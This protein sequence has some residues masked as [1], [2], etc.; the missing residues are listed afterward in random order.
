MLWALNTSIVD[1]AA[2]STIMIPGESYGVIS[3][4][5]SKTKAQDVVNHGYYIEALKAEKTE[6]GR[7]LWMP[8]VC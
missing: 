4:G 8:F 2:L 1:V 6:L 5:C 7:R 3:Y